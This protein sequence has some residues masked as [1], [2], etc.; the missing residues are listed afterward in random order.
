[1]IKKFEAFTS[2]ANTWISK[3]EDAKSI[4]ECFQNVSDMDNLTINFNS[5]DIDDDY[6]LYEVELSWYNNATL[7]DPENFSNFLQI[8]EEVDTSLERVKDRGY[9]VGSFKFESFKGNIQVYKVGKEIRKKLFPP[10]KQGLV[11]LSTSYIG[12]AVLKSTSSLLIK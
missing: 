11:G 4:S 3:D 2:N 1:M 12:E 8:M 6:T 5:Y 10:V 7:L 9:V